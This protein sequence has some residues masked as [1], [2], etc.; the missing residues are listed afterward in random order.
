MAQKTIRGSE[1]L[2]A[3]IRRRRGEL[4]LT[5]EEA[6]SR[7]GVGTKT[8]CRYEAGGSIRRD[9]SRGICKALNWGGLPELEEED[10][11]SLT[12]GEYRSHEAWSPFLERRFGPRAAMSFAAGSDMVLDKLKEDLAELAGMPVGTH[13]GQLSASWLDGELPPQFRMRYDYDLLYRM[14]CELLRLRVRAGAGLPMTAHSVMDELLMYLC[15]EEAKS[16]IELSGGLRDEADPGE[17]ED[18][19]FDLF[20]DMDVVTFLYSDMYLDPEHAYHFSHWDEQQFFMDEA[21]RP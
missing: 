9:K 19:V 13:I 5:I 1:D 6:A 2:G 7:A 8:W 10:V 4:G 16:L 11:E 17:D 21:E 3:R 12:V 14:K 15:N 20:E 18:W